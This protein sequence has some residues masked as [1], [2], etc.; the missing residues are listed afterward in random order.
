MALMPV[1]P[2]AQKIMIDTLL[3]RPV[4]QI[5]IAGIPGVLAVSVNDCHIRN[6]FANVMQ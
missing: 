1:F 3:C 4:G 2:P 5:F 6:R